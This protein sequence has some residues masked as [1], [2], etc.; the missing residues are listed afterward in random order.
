MLRL[1]ERCD[2][3]VARLAH[4]E[5]DARRR[6]TREDGSYAERSDPRNVR[7]Q[8]YQKRRRDCCQ[9]TTDC[10]S[11]VSVPPQQTT[12]GLTHGSLDNYI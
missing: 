11:N 2:G 9:V 1:T 6:A 5:R 12:R 3:T 7:Q 8:Q 4:W 10:L